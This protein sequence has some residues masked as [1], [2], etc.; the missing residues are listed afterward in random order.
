M[1]FAIAKAA[2]LRGA[3]VTLIA[4]HTEIEPPMFV[5][6]VRVGS[7]AEM[8]EAVKAHFD[9]SDIV[10]KAAAVADYTPV[11]VADNK[12]KKSDGDMSIS[13]KRTT[14]ILKYLGENK[15]HQF[16]CGFSME[17]ENMLE[18]SLKKLKSK[19][20]DMIAA[21]S[22]KQVGAGFGTDTNIITLITRNNVKE[23]PIM[24]KAEAADEIL[25]AYLENL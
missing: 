6:V 13:L 22:L 23:L 17:T 18:N 2:M 3:E 5:N 25:N 7:A 16:L 15:K 21:N 10:I 9:E 8:F 1:G 11:T 24:S 19:N 14:D 4:A 20:V 12:I